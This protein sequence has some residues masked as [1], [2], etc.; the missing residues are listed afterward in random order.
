MR[1]FA[2]R[3]TT[4]ILSGLIGLLRAVE[5]SAV[6]ELRNIAINLKRDAAAV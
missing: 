2:W 1:F 6:K 4:F 5:A 3:V